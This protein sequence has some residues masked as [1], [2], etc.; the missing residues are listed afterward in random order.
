VGARLWREAL[1]RRGYLAAPAL[2]LFALLLVLPCL[3]GF[4][5]VVRF[6]RERIDIAVH[7]D[8]VR[9]VGQYV[10]KN[11]WPF[12]VTQ[13]LSIPLPVDAAHPM[14]T[15]LAAARIA[16]DAGPV[17][18]RS[19]L[20]QTVMEIGFRPREEV[21][22]V[23]QYRQYAPAGP[24]ASRQTTCPVPLPA[25]ARVEYAS[26]GS[27]F[28]V[29]MLPKTAFP[30][31]PY[32]YLTSQPSYRADGSGQIRMIEVHDRATACPPD[33]PVVAQVGEADIEKMR[34]LLAGVGEC[35]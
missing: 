4:V 34:Q 3:A 16:P 7:P 18:L 17:P 2:G 32:N 26:D 1:R 10:Y 21:Q 6:V 20:G 23:V 5:P 35:P 22:V 29:F 13:G 24:E 33:A 12:P 19:I 31:F 30:F 27:G 8:E 28:T 25:G 15:E 14:P 11:P 9:V